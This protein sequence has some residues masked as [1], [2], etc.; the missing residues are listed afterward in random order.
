MTGSPVTI[1]RV[2]IVRGAERETPMQ[3][4]VT[5]LRDF[6]GAVDERGTRTRGFTAGDTPT[7][8]ESVAKA[9][10]EAGFVEILPHDVESDDDQGGGETV[11][12]EGDHDAPADDDRDALMA[13]IGHDRT[14]GKKLVAWL[15]D[16]DVAVPRGMRVPE[17]R[18]LAADVVERMD[19]GSAGA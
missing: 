17:I 3:V 14:T 16:H 5:V 18:G 12:P 19:A 8:P 13:W 1:D 10:A 2:P 11:P 4:P 6:E 9:H 15:H 7:L